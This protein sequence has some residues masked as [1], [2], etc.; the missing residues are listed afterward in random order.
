MHTHFLVAVLHEDD[1]L[2]AALLERLRRAIDESLH[3]RRIGKLVVHAHADA[4]EPGDHVGGARI[5]LASGLRGEAE[6]RGTEIDLH[7]RFRGHAGNR[8]EAEWALL[9]LRERRR[10]EAARYDG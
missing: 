1:A 8:V 3:G 7:V 10:Q 4:A 6:Q 9:L 2:P 5:A